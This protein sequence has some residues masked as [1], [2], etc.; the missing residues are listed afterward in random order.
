MQKNMIP[1][2]KLTVGPE[3]EWLE[4]EILLRGPILSGYVRGYIVENRWCFKE[5]G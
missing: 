1:S 3:I 2:L 5:N 4:D